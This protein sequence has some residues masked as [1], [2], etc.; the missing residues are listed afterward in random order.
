MDVTTD[1]DDAVAVAVLIRALVT[2]ATTLAIAGDPGPRI[3]AEVLRSAYWRAARDGWCGNGVDAITGHI[4]PTAAQL[5][6]LVAHVG[7]ALEAA[8]DTSVVDALL[9]R[10]HAR[11]TG[12]EMQRA[13]ARRRGSLTDVVDDL[14]ATT[15]RR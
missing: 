10:L 7:A 5:E 12:A 15:A 4:L 8:G 6:N 14:T 11:G 2:T 13:S 1:V 9:D 3:S